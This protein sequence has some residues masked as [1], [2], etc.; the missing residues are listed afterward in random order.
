MQRELKDWGLALP[1]FESIPS[2]VREAAS[3]DALSTLLSTQGEQFAC[4]LLEPILGSGGIMVPSPDYCGAISRLCREHDVLLIADEVA[5]G[6]G[7]CGAFF[8]SKLLGFDADIIALS[9]GLTAG[10]FPLGATLFSQRVIEPLSARGVAIPYGSTQDG[11]PVGCAAALAT[12]AT[13]MESDLMR[14]ATE[15]GDGIQAALRE[16]VGTCVV[17]Q[18]RGKGLMIGIELA[19]QGPIPRPFS[20]D[21]SAKVRQECREEGLL[22]YHFDAGISLFPPLTIADAEVGDMIQILQY[23]LSS[24]S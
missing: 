13:I 18:V 20:E 24:Q 10:Y 16:M 23:V 12:I 7:R 2:P 17:S 1:Q 8:A 9:K 22:V 6:G 19:H 4:L 14:R 3:L 21:E 5:T 15:V 11:N